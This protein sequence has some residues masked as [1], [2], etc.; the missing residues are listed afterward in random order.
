MWH[1]KIFN[2][3]VSQQCIGRCLNKIMIIAIFLQKSFVGINPKL[4]ASPVMFSS[5]QNRAYEGCNNPCIWQVIP[6]F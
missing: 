6:F 5:C 4:P 2:Q 3:P 1:N